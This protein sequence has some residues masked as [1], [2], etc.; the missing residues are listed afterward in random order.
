MPLWAQ[1]SADLRRRCAEGAFADGVP[2]EHLL[3]Q[4][5]DVSRHTMREALRDLR[6]E[7]VIRSQ[8]GR[9]SVV[10]GSAFSQDIGSVYSLFRS[11]E[12]QGAIQTSDVLKLATTTDPRV[13]SR[14]ALPS[15]ASLIVLERVR[16]ADGVPLAHDTSWLPAALAAPLLDADFRRTALYDELALRVGIHVDSG[17]ETISARQPDPAV[18]ALLDMPDGVATLFFERLG[19]AQGTPVEW[20]ETHVRGDRYVVQA[21]WRSSS[22][23]PLIMTA[24]H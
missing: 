7:G 2:G 22:A 17:T 18:A 23:P 20:R 1:V 10:Q 16:R 3:A 13:A 21:D 9:A 24:A 11:V 15:R 19:R 5:Y 12:A 14:L 8:R 6:A 4:Q